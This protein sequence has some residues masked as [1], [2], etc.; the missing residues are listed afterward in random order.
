MKAF[1][2]GFA[3]GIILTAATGWYFAFARKDERVMHAQD[4]VAGH[5]EH[6]VDV[7][8]ARLDAFELNGKDVREDLTRT[9]RVVRRRAREAGA[10]IADAT[11]D[12]R[13]TATIK[14][15]LIADRELSAWNISVNT[16]GGHV[17]LAGTVASHDLIGR[18]MLLA[19]ESDGVS[20]V[21]STLQV[22]Q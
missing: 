2:A 18:A 20:E 15:K 4:V 5:L 7:M 16:T 3:L 22:K 6:A 21:T 8:N 12:T 17:T 9:G 10:A 1:F 19:L 13:I 14:A 11:V